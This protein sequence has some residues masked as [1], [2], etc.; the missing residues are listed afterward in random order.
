VTPTSLPAESA[1]PN[2]DLP[3]SEP[4]PGAC[5]RCGADLAADADFATTRVCAACGYHD[6]E[7]ARAAIVRLVDPDSFRERDV[8]LV[9]RDPLQFEDERTYRDRLHTLK[10]E[11]GESDA[12]ITGTARLNGHEIAIAALDFGFLGGSMGVVVGEKLARAAELARREKRALVTVVGSGGARMQEGLLSLLQM[13]KTASQVQELKDA[14]LPFISVL[15]NPTTGGVFASFASLGDVVYAEPKSLIG[16]AGPRVAE[17]VLGRPL[18]P[19]SHS[20]EFL[21]EHGFVD[22]VVPR[23]HLRSAIAL[24]L[25]TIGSNV[26]RPKRTRLTSGPLEPLEPWEAVQ[27]ARDPDR[28]TTLHYVS[29]C[30]DYWIELHGDRTGTDDRSV[31]AG[32]GQLEGQAVAV[33]GFERGS[34]HDPVDRRGGRPMP[35]G[36]RKAQRLMR[37]ASRF[38]IP[39]IAFIDTP[40]AY[41]GIESEEE[42]LAFEIATTMAAMIRVDAPTISVIVGEGGSGGALAF[43]VADRV[44]MQ[45]RA[46]YSV[47]APEGAAAILYRDASRAPEL[48][49]Q[50]KITAQEVRKLGI[51]DGTIPEPKGGAKADPVTAARRVKTAILDHLAEVNRMDRDKR[52]STRY[53]RYRTIGTRYLTEL[54]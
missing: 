34:E 36:Y 23:H 27:T 29:E 28:P 13:A 2:A 6:R 10:G 25:N 18:P 21:L 46:I 37:L 52:K 51:S 44:L 50:L 26:A 17:Q 45:E 1:P 24:T 16:F 5:S 40:G 12:L 53:H 49:D 9:S 11:T 30:L 31:I 32:L 20:A 43:A 54:K 47:I 3:A 7:S 38:R 33:I 35:G 4:L 19:G 41:P 42:G 48:A 8:N 15:T 39:L 14:G 22:S